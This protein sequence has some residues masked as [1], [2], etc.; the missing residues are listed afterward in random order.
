MLQKAKKTL[1]IA[2]VLV[3]AISLFAAITPSAAASGGITAYP[4]ASTV[5]VNGGNVGFDAYNIADN[6]Y[7]KLRDLAQT[8]R[9]TAKQFEVDWDRANNA[10]RLT[11]GIPYTDVGG[12]MEGKGVGNKTPLPTSSKVFLDGEEVRFTAYNIEDNNYF[13]LRD[14]GEALNF[15]VDWDGAR[16]TIVIDTGKGYTPE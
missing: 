13:K 3:I 2:L 12:E 6:N 14:V 15:G 5:L 8:L 10:I 4:T 1:S 7:F 11:S 16:N 9:G